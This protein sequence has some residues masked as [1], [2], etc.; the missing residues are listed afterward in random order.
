MPPTRNPIDALLDDGATAAPNALNSFVEEGDEAPGHTTSSPARGYAA[1][2]AKLKIIDAKASKAPSKVSRGRKRDPAHFYF[3][4]DDSDGDDDEDGAQDLHEQQPEKKAQPKKKATRVKS[5][6]SDQKRANV[7]LNADDESEATTHA[8]KTAVDDKLHD[9]TKSAT[10]Q[11]AHQTGGKKASHISTKTAPVASKGTAKA[12]PRLASL[13]QPLVTEPS[14]RPIRKAK[15]TA[16]GK[17]KAKRGKD[18]DDAMSDT[19]DESEDNASSFGAKDDSTHVSGCGRGRGRPPKAHLPTPVT[20]SNTSK[21]DETS[22]PSGKLQSVKSKVPPTTASVKGASGDTSRTGDTTTKLRTRKDASLIGEG[23]V[24]NSTET[25]ND[26][27][28]NTS[29][30]KALIPEDDGDDQDKKEG[31]LPARRPGALK[32]PARSASRGRM[33]LRETRYD[34][35]GSTPRVKRKNRSVSK[36]SRAS[37]KP[38]A[39]RQRM[40]SESVK[41][42]GDPDIDNSRQ[43]S[44]SHRAASKEI[45]LGSPPRKKSTAQRKSKKVPP[46]PKP[47]H[48]NESTLQ[49]KRNGVAANAGKLKNATGAKSSTSHQKPGSSQGNAIMIEQASQSSSSPSPGPYKETMTRPTATGQI[50]NRQEVRRLQTPAVMPSSPPPGGSETLNTLARDKPT[51]IAFSK[52]GPR[53]QGIAL[54]SKD[55][56]SDVAPTAHPVRSTADVGISGLRGQERKLSRPL[57]PSQDHAPVTMGPSNVSAIDEGIFADF[58]KNGKNQALTSLLQRAAAPQSTKRKD[59]PAQERDEDDGFFAIDDFDDTTLVNGDE[60]A[61][62]PDVQRTASQIAMPPPNG[63]ERIVKKLTAHNSLL[64]NPIKAASKPTIAKA[65]PEPQKPKKAVLVTTT[66]KAG[67][68]KPAKQATKVESKTDAKSVSLQKATKIIPLHDAIETRSTKEASIEQKAQPKRKRELNELQSGSPQKKTKTL[69]IN[70]PKASSSD[71]ASARQ[72]QSSRIPQGAKVV[73]ADPVERP[74][75]RRNRPSRRTTQGSQ[76]VDILGSPYPKELEVPIQTTALEIFSQQADLS[77][78]QMASSDAVFA[79]GLAGRLNLAAVPRI[80]P[81]THRKPMSSNGKPL[82]AAPTESSRAAT[83]IA[84]GPLAE[85]LIT[86]KHEQSVMEDPFTSSHKRAPTVKQTAQAQEPDFK[87]AL[88]KQG[89]IIDQQNHTTNHDEEEEEEEDPDKTFVNPI[90]TLEG[91]DAPK[92]DSIGTS[93][94][95]TS[96]E[97]SNASSTVVSAAQQALEDIGDWRNTLRP[98]QTHLF[99]SLVIASHRLVRHLVDGETAHRDIVADYRRRGEIVVAELERS[100]ARDLEKYAAGMQELK[101]RAADGLA[102][103]GK[104]LR[105][106][107]KE[108]ERGRDGRRE[109]KVVRDNGFEGLLE[110]LVA[111]LG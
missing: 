41:H 47:N 14:G 48:D 105:A 80:L 40:Q 56:G 37:V 6:A 99:D 51:I 106:D 38:G 92:E 11:E 43:M 12:T 61:G 35:P 95:T 29:H 26:A 81:P 96:D 20:K 79:G 86:A 66:K 19:D 46:Q 65:A 68:P 75:R 84:S 93:P 42:P 71:E 44:I 94:A 101:T 31:T 52:R 69:Q 24:V 111:G 97:V 88:R 34:F 25:D 9:A 1:L 107:V 10:A 89:I 87:Q 63:S 27:P 54:S 15:K 85:Q 64:G 59:E 5:Q 108:G 7:A 104:R 16:L 73:V 57:F 13:S 36:A 3:E 83:R 103:M 100:H 30:R 23:S 33:P 90:S 91:D 62:K 109:A 8:A 110:G 50:R 58:T 72:L 39:T 21:R 74:D 17:L 32:R 45:E 76:G 22:K 55:P 78:D 70:P 67:E 28:K 60:L 49:S 98:H 77:S 18:N 2:D 82:P 53:N 4:P 102:S